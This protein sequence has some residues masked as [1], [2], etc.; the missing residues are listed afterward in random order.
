M[1]LLVSCASSVHNKSI[2][3]SKSVHALYARQSLCVNVLIAGYGFLQYHTRWI[4][5]DMEHALKQLDS[6]AMIA[7][8]RHLVATPSVYHPD[9]PDANETAVARIIYDLLRSWGWSPVWQLV[10]PSRPNVIADLEGPGGTGRC[11]MFEGHTD[12]VTP[13]ERVAWTYDPYGATIVDGRL[14]GR[15]AADM[16]AGLAAMLFAA[17]AIQTS[18]VLFRG[19]IRLAIPV[20]EEGLMLGIK[21]LV[22]TGY[23]DDVDAAIICEP[24]ERQVCIAQ[25]GSLRLHVLSHGRI[26]HGAMPY[27]GVNALTAMV[28]LLHRLL[29]LE[30]RLQQRHGHHP[31]LGDIHLTPTVLRAPLMADPSQMNCLP[32]QCDVYLDIRSLPPTSHEQIIAAIWREIDALRIDYPAYRFDLE[33]IDDRPATETDINDAVVQAVVNAHQSVYGSVPVFGGVPGATDGTILWR[34]RAIPIVVY[35]PG[36]KHIPHQPDEYV[37]LDEVVRAAQVYIV[38]ALTYLGVE[39]GQTRLV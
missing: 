8:L 25:K 27:K 24:E 35:G 12:V 26:A 4:H 1:Q 32:G 9:Q 21:A 15:G 28:R 19:R 23:A 39:A 16:K 33:V 7:F 18:G 2:H 5:M 29:D 14:Y 36:N 11:L 34:D 38:A 22:A 13:G 37:E 10:T 30:A 20:D 6:H 3:F 17:R 31:L